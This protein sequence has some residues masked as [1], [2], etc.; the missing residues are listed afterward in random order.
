[1]RQAS[2]NV[3]GLP[4]SHILTV[5]MIEGSQSPQ[6]FLDSLK[7]A[8]R[9]AFPSRPVGEEYLRLHLEELA[10]LGIEGVNPEAWFDGQLAT[11]LD[12]IAGTLSPNA[13]ALLKARVAVGTAE[14]AS[15]NAWII[16]SADGGVYAILI[17]R[18]LLSLM[19]HYV[20]L[21]AAA[22]D[23]AAV[24]FFE[25]HSAPVLPSATYTR[26]ASIMLRRYAE[27]G[28]VH[29]PELKFRSD[30]TTRLLVDGRLLMTHLF[31]LAHEV[32]HYVNGDLEADGHFSAST[33]MNGAEVFG[34]NVSHAM[35]FAADRFAFEA[36]LRL[37]FASDPSTAA[38]IALY[39][40]AT[41]LF[42]VLREIGNSGS[43]SHPRP[44]DRLLAIVQ[45]FFG[46]EAAL[47][48]AKS[49]DD[50]SYVASFGDHVGDRSVADLL[51]DR[52]NP[53]SHT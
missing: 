37:W 17:H 19:N 33:R 2:T 25:G 38:T 5:K 39:S 16:R 8:N 40:S 30:S 46:P 50:L 32:G 3:R 35:E 18:G 47:L 45:S 44:S 34:V 20:K 27:S 13:Q 41:L 11:M 12:R 51:C 4:T 14:L 48:L 10:S 43:L 42:N 29:G 21:T 24:S 31:V 28:E 7:S 53:G 6:G 52:A 22:Q 36:V 9:D 49:F 23:P 15:A 26:V 1:M